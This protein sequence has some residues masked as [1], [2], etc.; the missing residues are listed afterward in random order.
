M[1]KIFLM[2]LT[3]VH[4]IPVAQAAT[5]FSIAATVNKSAIS[6][7]DVE[8]RMQLLLASSGM[9][10]TKEND[11]RIRPQALDILIEEELKIQEAE[12]NNLA[13]TPEELDQAFQAMAQ[14]NK[15]T[16]EQFIQVMQQ[17]GIPKATLMRQ[18]KAQ[19]SWTKVITSILRPQVDVS[20]NDINA[21]MERVKAN[22]GKMEYQASE[23][24]LPVTAENDDTSIG[25]LATKLV[26]EMKLGRAPFDVVA[27]QF[28]KSNTAPQGGA[29]GW[30]QEGQL[31]KEL[32]V[33]LKS[34]SQGQISPPIKSLDGYYILS[35]SDKR[36]VAGE[37]LPSED[38]VLN[39]IGLERLDRL[40][41]RY[42]ADIRSAAFIDKR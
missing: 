41:Q 10:S 2:L 19:I 33:V 11:A 40:Q 8:D 26:E 13:V 1:I 4:F 38:A 15:L 35:V 34:L 7:A 5:S 29:M 39:S 36:S 21:K 31:P 42:L 22:I 30:V 16:P 6:E 23:I 24:F 14:Q 3:F 32:D 20:E 25:E 12:K 17:Q 27:L 18:I 37:S 28:S 9:R